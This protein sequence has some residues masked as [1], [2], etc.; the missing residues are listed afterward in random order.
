MEKIEV[1]Y[2]Y[3][4]LRADLVTEKGDRVSILTGGRGRNYSAVPLHKLLP[5]HVQPVLSDWLENTLRQME[6]QGISLL[7]QIAFCLLA[8]QL[9]RKYRAVSVYLSTGSE[10]SVTDFMQS[11][12][13]YFHSKNQIYTSLNGQ[14]RFF[15]AAIFM[16]DNKAIFEKT[17]IRPG[18]R[19]V[20]FAEEP[21]FMD[22]ESW[23]DFQ[24]FQTQQGYVQTAGL[25]VKKP[26][27]FGRDE[28]KNKAWDEFLESVTELSELLRSL[29]FFTDVELD[30][31]IRQIGALERIIASLY[32]DLVGCDD[33]KYNLN[34]VKEAVIHYRLAEQQEK[35]IWEDVCCER[36]RNLVVS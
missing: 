31:L 21:F 25:R 8:E 12:I 33:I 32:D 4:D 26:G 9:M 14:E 13:R 30:A 1:I 23:E 17:P 6:E 10:Q 27:Y 29:S 5:T 36:V 28:E 24:C 3:T 19:V 34:L 20:C 18:G 2:D 35:S 22:E 16:Q 7:W 15:D 11:A